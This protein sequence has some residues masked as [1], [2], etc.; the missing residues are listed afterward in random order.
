MFALFPKRINLL[1]LGSPTVWVIWM[2]LWL[3]ASP[4]ADAALIEKSPW[5]SI[6]WEKQRIHI[7]VPAQS[8][9]Q[10][11]HFLTLSDVIRVA[12]KHYRHLIQSVRLDSATTLGEW[13]EE[14]VV[15]TDELMA[16]FDQGHIQELWIDG[17]GHARCT[18]DVPLFGQMG[19]GTRAYLNM[20]PSTDAPLPRSFLQTNHAQ[21]LGGVYTGLIIDARHLPIR[22]CLSI[23]IMD[24]SGKI[25]Y[26]V[27]YVQ[28]GQ[29]LNNGMV[30]YKTALNRCEDRVGK[31]PLSIKAV[32]LQGPFKSDIVVSNQQAHWIRSVQKKHHFLDKAKVIILIPE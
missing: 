6:D 9:I 21:L 29:M 17:M 31:H 25:V 26:D 16:L 23:K 18:I 27:S 4:C 8:P 5:G 14:D 20:V 3:L 1:A 30:A 2:A 12:R 32:S 11:V 28:F 24:E 22:P 13:L 19:I 10:P 15:L 7:Q